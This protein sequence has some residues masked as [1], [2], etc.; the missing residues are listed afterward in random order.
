MKKLFSIFLMLGALAVALYAQATAPQVLDASATVLAS[1]GTVP[2]IVRDPANGQP[3]PVFTRAQKALFDYLEQRSQ[4]TTRAALSKGALVFDPIT[5]YIRF[6][7]TGLS[8]RQQ[9]VSEGTTK[10]VGV[11]NFDRG[12]LRQY[13]NFCFDRISVRYATANSVTTALGGLA[14]SSVRGGTMDPA[15]ANGELIVI[16]NKNTIIETPVMDFVSAAAITG[17]GLR[18]YDGGILEAPKVLEE[19]KQVEI[20]I[21][22]AGTVPSATNTIYGVEVALQGVQAR[23]NN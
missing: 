16:Q 3:I 18:E 8:G 12:L 6:A 20:W 5:Y 1:I 22:L 11:T 15:L 7:I 10:A 17:G 21:S 19:N 2:A 4:G 13:Y 14:Y 9:I 23:I